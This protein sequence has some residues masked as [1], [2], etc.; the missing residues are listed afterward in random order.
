[1]SFVLGALA[2]FIRWPLAA[3][4]PALV[5]GFLY[6][7]RQLPFSLIAAILWAL[8]AVYESL[9]KVRVLCSGECNIRIDLLAL[10]PLLA[11][12]SLVAL[13]EL[14]VRRRKRPPHGAP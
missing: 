9:M 2:F 14:A 4:V 1:M 5:F 7:R 6:F 12:V 8:Y 13:I 10:Y 3:L 11:I